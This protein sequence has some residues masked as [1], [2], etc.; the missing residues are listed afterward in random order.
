MMQ[1]DAGGLAT[2]ILLSTITVAC[3]VLFISDLVKAFD[4]IQSLRAF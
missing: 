1:C 2:V 4:F 3:R